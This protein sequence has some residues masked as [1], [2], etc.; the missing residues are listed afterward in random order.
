MTDHTPEPWPG[1]NL[2]GDRVS[3]SWADYQRAQAC[4]NACAGIPTAQL[5]GIN[6]LDLLR[7]MDFAHMKAMIDPDQ[8]D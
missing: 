3:L 7:Q 6:I 4:V 5:E 8:K 1:K 2:H